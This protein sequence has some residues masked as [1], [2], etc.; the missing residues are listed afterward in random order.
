LR[1][2]LAENTAEYLGWLVTDDELV[3]DTSKFNTGQIAEMQSE[4]GQV[5][6][7]RLDGFFSP[8]KLRLRPLQMSAEG[9]RE[10]TSMGAKKVID[11]PGWLPAIN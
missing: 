7:W 10:D 2:A 9:L 8:S 5:R 3:I 1:K 6:R 4:F 11:R